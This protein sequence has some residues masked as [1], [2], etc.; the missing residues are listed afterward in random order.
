[1]RRY[2]IVHTTTLAYDGPV[3][4]AHNELR[5]TPLNE[6]GQTTLENRIRIRPMTWS[7]VYRDHWGTHVMAMESLAEHSALDI[8]ATSTV[9]RTALDP[10][11]PT[12]DWE[13]VHDPSVQDRL[14]EWL[15]LSGRTRPGQGLGELVEDAR[16]L[17]SP[18]AAAEEVCR[19]VRA[20]MEYR[21]GVTGVHSH[22][23]EAWAEGAGV[24]QDFAH[25]TV[26]TLRSLGIPARYVS[27]YLVPRKG[28]EV[29][30]SA[31]GE[32][33]AWVEFWDDAWVP[34]DP[35]NGTEVGLE[36]VVVA[37]GRDYDDVPPFKGIYSGQATA[38][39]T[40][41]VSITR[42]A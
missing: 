8:E 38:T 21:P 36:H 37:R 17:P 4:A 18:R 10:P 12:C 26:G 9:E 35:T 34:A 41:D 28:L 22:G 31:T 19:R 27:G 16:S 30:M 29:G 5:M 13:T 32:S 7:H 33:H 3:R 24:C 39:L 42:L 1:M 11:A 40:V 6:P 23:E 25:V 15:M 20:G 2:R 14:Y